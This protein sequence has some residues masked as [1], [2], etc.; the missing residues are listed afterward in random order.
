MPYFI[1]HISYEIWH[2]KFCPTSFSLGEFSL[3]FFLDPDRFD[4]DEFADALARKLAPVARTLHPAEGQSRVGRD[5]GVDEDQAGIDLIDQA[6][7]LLVVIGPGAGG[8]AEG[9]IVCQ[10]DRLVQVADAEERGDR[11]EHLFEIARRIRG[12]IRENR[13]RDVVARSHQPLASGKDSASL[14]HSLPHLFFESFENVPRRERAYVSRLVHRVADLE[15]FHA[16]DEPALEFV[17]DLLGDDEALGRD[18]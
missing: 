6:A 9:R 7:A 12:N 17:A 4:V 2:M 16:L 5:H 1:C 8:Q 11:A 3:W 14:R 18:A 15:R 10:T 13:R